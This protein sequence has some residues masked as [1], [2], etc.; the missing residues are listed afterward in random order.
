MLLID[1]KGKYLT[2]KE[3]FDEMKTLEGRLIELSHK[4]N[5]TLTITAITWKDIVV[6]GGKRDDVMLNNTIKRE[7]LTS[8][9]D[10]V[11]DSYDSYKE[12]TIDKIREMI[13][14][15]SVDYCIVYFRDTLH[16]K[17]KDICKLFHYGRSQAS[18]KYSDFKNRT[19]SDTIGH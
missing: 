4:Y 8:E 2:I 19:S 16:W 14:N 13:A 12:E 17:W 15:E 9:F 3:L 1:A 6:K 10:I 7:E 5:R 11:K 18:K